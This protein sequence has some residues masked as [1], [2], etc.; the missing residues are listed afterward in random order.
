MSVQKQRPPKARTG[1]YPQLLVYP[2]MSFA[3]TDTLQWLSVAVDQIHGFVNL[4]IISQKTARA[5][6]HCS[7][8]CILHFTCFSSHQNAF[9]MNDIEQENV[10]PSEKFVI[11]STA[12]GSS[13]LKGSLAPFCHRLTITTLTYSDISKTLAFKVFSFKVAP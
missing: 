12:I 10:L 1:H 8:L 13:S 11:S 6:N 9:D 5:T 4:G 7:G 3:T 2:P